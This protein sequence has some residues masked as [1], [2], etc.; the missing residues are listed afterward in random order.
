MKNIKICDLCELN[1]TNFE[2][3]FKGHDRMLEIEGEFGLYHCNNCGLYFINPQPDEKELIK[4]YPEESYC[5]YK[6]LYLYF[7]DHKN[8]FKKIKFITT[9]LFFLLRNIVTYA[10]YTF[11]IGLLRVEKI[12]KENGNILDL[13]CGNGVFLSRLRKRALKKNSKMKFYGIDIVEPKNKEKLEEFG[14]KI[15]KGTIFEMKFADNMFDII[16][17][18]HVLEHVHNPSMHFKELKRI[19]KPGGILIISV[20]NINSLNFKI[21]GKNWFPLDIPRH[22]FDFSEETLRKYLKKFDLKIIKV[23]YNSSQS[24]FLISLDYYLSKFRKKYVAPQ[25]LKLN[26]SI[27]LNLVLLPIVW[28]CNVLKIGD[29]LEIICTKN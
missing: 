20:P 22:L 4:F 13:G 23:R 5:S 1:N 12:L 14:I 3:V 25:K 15:L 11:L 2:F 8:F 27:V 7:M 26:N 24:H 6:S 21:F 17:L 9:N 18:Y 10:T 29:S 16:R 28:I 19:L